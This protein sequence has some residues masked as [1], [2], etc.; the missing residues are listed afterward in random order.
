MI[1]RKLNLAHIGQ[2]I[3]PSKWSSTWLA[4]PMKVSSTW[5]GKFKSHKN[6]SKVVVNKSNSKSLNSLSSTEPMQDSLFKFLMPAEKFCQINSTLTKKT[7]KPSQF[8]LYNKRNNNKARRVKNKKSKRN[9]LKNKPKSLL[10]RWKPGLITELLIWEPLLNTPSSDYKAEFARSSDSSYS[11]K[12]LSKFIPQRWSE[13]H[14]RV[15]LTFLIS[16][17]LTERLV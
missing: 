12:I 3:C 15:D 9:K 7:K 1:L 8:R 5:L 11:L 10:S 2:K 14:Q 17:I 6:P 16:T 4:F 13:A